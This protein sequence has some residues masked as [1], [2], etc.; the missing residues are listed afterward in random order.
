MSKLPKPIRS[1]I[2][3]LSRLPGIGPKSAAR[4]VFYLLSKSENSSAGL[5]EAI[6]KLKQG[7]TICSVCFNWTE[8]DPCEICLAQDRDEEVICIV[9][10]PLDVIA[11]DRAGFKGKYHVIGGAISP[12]SGIGPDDLRIA[13]VI[14]RVKENSDKIKEVI[15][16]TNPSLEGEAT[17]VYIDERIKPFGIKVTRLARGLPVGGDLEYADDLTLSRSLEGRGEL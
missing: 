3:E 2:E 10:E 13:E 7:L 11:L 15:L 16:A 9:E 14:K 17:A 6:L 12:I 5:G 1:A 8:S 4:I